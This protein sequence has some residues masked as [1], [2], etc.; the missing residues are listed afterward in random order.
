LI[1]LNRDRDTLLADHWKHP[2]NYQSNLKHLRLVRN[3]VVADKVVARDPIGIFGDGRI[4]RN[5]VGGIG[6]PLELAASIRVTVDRILGD[7]LAITPPHGIFLKMRRFDFTFAC[8]ARALK[9]SR[10]DLILPIGRQGARGP[11]GQIAEISE[12]VPI[13]GFD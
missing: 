6:K 3:R 11:N 5:L 7:H 1:C 9:F 13:L 2:A 8:Y 4:P 10:E 12:L